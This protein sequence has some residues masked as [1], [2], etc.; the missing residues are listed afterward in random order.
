MQIS[1][2]D[3]LG[4]MALKKEGNA[5]RLEGPGVSHDVI[6]ANA[7]LGEATDRVHVEANSTTRWDFNCATVKKSKA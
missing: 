1:I 2:I 4:P 6:P 3:A 7:V 5:R